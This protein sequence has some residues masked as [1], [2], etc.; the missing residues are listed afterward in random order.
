MTKNKSKK[1]TKS[2]F[3]IIIMA[4]VMV[5]MIAFGGTYA[6]FTATAEDFT[7]TGAHTALI[8]LE[9]GKT[10]AV[11]V[12]AA[13]ALPGEKVADVTVNLEDTSTRDTYVFALVS[14]KFGDGDVIT[15]LEA[16]TCPVTVNM[17]TG[18]QTAGFD[19]NNTTGVFY[20][21]RNN[22]KDGESDTAE[23]AAD[24]FTFD[25]D[26]TLKS[27]LSENNAEG[28]ADESLEFMDKDVT[29]TIVFAAIQSDNGEGAKLD[30][31]VAY[32]ALITSAATDGDTLP[33]V[34][35]GA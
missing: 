8:Q 5:A 30:V 10:E 34:K 27:T 13:H 20:L 4:V 32:E 29:V 25:A 24:T 16:E 14:V 35:A 28:K 7:S 6:Y 1:M 19:V 31:Q 18:W 17:G 23:I 3:A 9:S 15:D 21:S 26:V 22:Y 12:N 11:Q 2:T 33:T